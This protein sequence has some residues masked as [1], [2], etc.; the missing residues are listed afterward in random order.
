MNLRNQRKFYERTCGECDKDIIT[1][2]ALDRP[3]RILCEECY[4][5]LV[6]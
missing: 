2:Y 1:T 4:R 5:K 6:Y 3:E